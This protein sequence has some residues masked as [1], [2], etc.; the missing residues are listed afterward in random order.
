MPNLKPPVTT[1]D[2]AL[3][4]RQVSVFAALAQRLH[5]MLRV[6]MIYSSSFAF[7]LLRAQSFEFE[8]LE[9]MI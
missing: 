7:E 9:C 4:Y 5:R 2:Q 3:E 1:T 6:A 8:M